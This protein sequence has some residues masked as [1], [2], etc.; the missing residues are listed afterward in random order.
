MMR[1]VNSKQN[2]PNFAQKRLSVAFSYLFGITYHLTQR[3]AN[4]GT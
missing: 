3:K 4:R 2:T 1:N